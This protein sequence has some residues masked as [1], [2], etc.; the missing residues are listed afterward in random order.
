MEK[1]ICP[2]RAVKPV[3]HVAANFIL[4]LVLTGVRACGPHFRSAT[5]STDIL[6]T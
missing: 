1:E 3:A 2:Q 4:L 6:A 5:V